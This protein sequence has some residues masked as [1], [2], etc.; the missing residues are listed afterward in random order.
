MLEARNT[1]Q[2]VLSFKMEVSV[3]EN[4][5]SEKTVTETTVLCWSVRT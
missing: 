2:H 1:R 5:V 3:L 4:I